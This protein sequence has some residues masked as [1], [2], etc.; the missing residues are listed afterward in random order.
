M[1]TALK[2]KKGD[3]V[4]MLTGKDRGQAGARPRRAPA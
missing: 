3:T 4:Q 2:M 1:T